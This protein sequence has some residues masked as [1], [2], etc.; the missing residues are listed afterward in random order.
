MYF[1]VRQARRRAYLIR[2]RRN[3]RI[4]PNIKSLNNKA[5][6]NPIYSAGPHIGK[7]IKMPVAKID[8]DRMQIGIE[9]TKAKQDCY[10]LSLDEIFN[11]VWFFFKN[12][13][14][15]HWSFEAWSRAK[16]NSIQYYER[17]LQQ[18]TRPLDN[19][20]I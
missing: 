18:I 8:S 3:Q 13:Q 15:N 14:L 9:N 12:G 4:L 11:L 17:I 5:A 19:P 1:A 20:A 16:K 10:T 7:M 6:L 2:Q